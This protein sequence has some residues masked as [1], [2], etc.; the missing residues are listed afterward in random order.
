MSLREGGIYCLPNGKELLVLPKNGHD[1]RRLK[2]RGWERF[3]MSEYE[4]SESGRLLSEG[5]LTAWDVGSLKDTG[6]TAPE[7][8]RSHEKRDNGNET[9]IA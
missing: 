1:S 6:R 5:K 7:F 8:S 2:L 9:L 3:E 4:L